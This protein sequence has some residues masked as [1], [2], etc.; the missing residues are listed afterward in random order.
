MQR[1]ANA[2]WS[3]SAQKNGG[4]LSHAIAVTIDAVLAS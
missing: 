4:T 3:D 1:K 2:C